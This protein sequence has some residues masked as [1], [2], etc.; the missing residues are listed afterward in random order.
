MLSSSQ[1]LQIHM[2]AR[3]TAYKP[4]SLGDLKRHGNPSHQPGDQCIKIYVTRTP[5]SR[6]DL[7]IL[8]DGIIA[9]NLLQLSQTGS[10][11]CMTRPLKGPT[12]L[13][14]KPVMK[15]GF[16]CYHTLLAAPLY[17]LEGFKAHETEAEVHWLI[18]SSITEEIKISKRFE[19][20]SQPSVLLLH[21]HTGLISGFIIELKH[22]KQWINITTSPRFAPSQFVLVDFMKSHP[23]TA[24]IK[25]EIGT[26]AGAHMHLRIRIKKARRASKH[27]ASAAKAAAALAANCAFMAAAAA[28][29]AVICDLFGGDSD[30][31]NESSD[32]DS[33]PDF[34][35][36]PPTRKRM[37][38]QISTGKVNID[39]GSE[40][41]MLL[42]KKFKSL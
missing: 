4:V 26:A 1:H 31:D 3:R 18:P 10:Y 32:S 35:S 25:H 24:A 29:D 7:E 15:T 16:Q 36:N 2:T 37:R 30:S 17:A 8:Q 28:D 11:D 38:D 42:C 21:T 19:D 12:G 9:G 20:R 14:N 34:E 39:S 40:M 5:D 33:E 13:W 27:A 6:C 41:M 23:S 22:V